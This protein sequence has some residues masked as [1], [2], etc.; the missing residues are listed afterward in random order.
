MSFNGATRLHAWKHTILK[1][2]AKCVISFNGAT[3]LHAWKPFASIP[4]S[5]QNQRRFNGATRLHAWKRRV[6]NLDCA[7]RSVASMGPRVFTRG[8]VRIRSDR[9]L[10]RTASMGPRVFTRGNHSARKDHI[11]RKAAS[12]GPR[13]FTRG[14]PFSFERGL[15]APLGL[16]WG[17]ASSRV[18]TSSQ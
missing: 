9:A 11:E 4:T 15:S 13:V 10:G 8:N 2:I 7:V 18:E 1:C 5:N 16:Q 14:N 12:M 6:L 17:H 3:R